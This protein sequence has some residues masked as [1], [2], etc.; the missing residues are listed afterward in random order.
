MGK[1]NLKLTALIFSGIII[2]ITSCGPSAAEVKEQHE[3]EK[4]ALA[5]SL[6]TVYEQKAEIDRKLVE[7]KR[8]EDEKKTTEEKAR[9]E[10]YNSRPEVIRE[11]LYNKEKTNPLDYLTIK[12][13]TDYSVWSSKDVLKGNIL[14]SATLTTFKDIK[15]K[16]HC[17]SKTK[18]LIKTLDYVL[19]E[20]VPA[21]KS[22]SFEIKFSSP[23]GT[24]S[25]GMEITNAAG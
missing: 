4:K 22:K 18:T 25:I 16:V 3:K 17:Y 15:I 10:E 14:N 11:K 23:P 8:L 20:F 9:L 12:Y 24:K 6:Q 5:D 7:E 13:N 21:R 1:L 19:Y 2:G